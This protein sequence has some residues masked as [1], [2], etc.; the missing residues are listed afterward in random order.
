MPCSAVMVSASRALV[1]LQQPQ[2][3][4]EDAGAAQ[5][6]GHRP[7]REGGAGE[8]HRV[9]HLRGAGQRHHTALLA[10]RGIVDRGATPTAAGDELAADEMMDL[11]RHDAT[12]ASWGVQASCRPTLATV[13]TRVA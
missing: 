4:V 9:V 2:E 1:L 8:V 13:S 6:R 10:S 7:G 11:G 5:G 12:S 3:A